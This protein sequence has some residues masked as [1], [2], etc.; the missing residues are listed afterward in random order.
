[1]FSPRYLIDRG[2]IQT[3]RRPGFR[4]TRRRSAGFGPGLE[5]LEDRTV[6]SFFIPPSFAVGTQP[7]GEA[8]GDL[9]GDGKLDIAVANKGANSVSILLGNGDGTFG[10]K[11]DSALPLTPVALTVGDFNGDGNADIAVATFN[12]TR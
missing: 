1:M 3:S 10:A 12:A 7:A 4:A 6:L 2:L 9:N 11:T 8:A 5:S